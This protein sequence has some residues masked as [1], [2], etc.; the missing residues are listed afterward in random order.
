MSL[1]ESPNV[2]NV[3]GTGEGI[4]AQSGTEDEPGFKVEVLW[5]GH[6][7]GSHSEV[8]VFAEEKAGK[9]GN[10]IHITLTFVGKGSIAYMDEKNVSLASSATRI[11]NIIDIYYNNVYNP[12][13][14]LGFKI[15]DIR[16]T[17]SENESDIGSYYPS[18]TNMNIP[19]P[20][21]E[22][23]IEFL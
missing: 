16:F 5:R 20:E 7:S 11:G 2:A 1:N 10:Y 9:S 12:K 4:F 6:N 13:E 3:Y 17:K 21:F 19:A 14:R 18:E 22:Y 15:N 23:K 8:E